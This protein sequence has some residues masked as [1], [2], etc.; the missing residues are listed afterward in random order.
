MTAMDGEQ[1]DTD[2]AAELRLMRQDL[3][4]VMLR[5]AGIVGWVWFAYVVFTAQAL[6]ASTLALLILGLGVYLAH[7]LATDRF[8]QACWVL[9]LSM[10][11]A[12]G[13][14]LSAHPFSLA[15]L[16][17][18]VI[19]VAAQALLPLGWALLAVGLAWASALVAHRDAVGASAEILSPIGLLLLYGLPFG[20]SAL[21]LRPL[22]TS[23]SWALAGWERAHES[24]VET[25]A[26]RA[27]LYRALRALEEAT[28]RI[29]RMNNEL[30]VARREAEEARAI[31]SRLTATVSHELRGPLNLILGFSKLMALSPESYGEPL[32]PAYRADIHAIYRNSR[33]LKALVD[34]ILDLSQIEAQQ[35]PLV[36]DLISLED[37]VVR[38]VAESIRPLAERKGL[39][40][41]LELAGD[42]PPVFGDPVRLRQALMNL[43]TNATRFTERGGIVVRTSREGG[44]VRVSVTDTGPGVR[45]ED[46][47][48]LFQ[49][50]H[51]IQP[52]RTREEGGSGLGLAISKHLIELHGGQIGVESQPGAGTTFFFTIPPVS[53]EGGQ[54]AGL[55]RT[56]ERLTGYVPPV[57]LAVHDDPDIVRLLGRYLEGYRVVGSPD[58]DRAIALAGQ[59]HARAILASSLLAGGVRA[60]LDR[61]GLDIPLITCGLPEPMM[62]PR[63][64]EVCGYLIKPITPELVASV[65]AQ[66]ERENEVNTVLLVD[67][68][69]DAVRLLERI[70]TAL[71]RPYTILKAYDGRQALE[72]MEATTPDVAFIDWVMPE[73]DG[74]E[75]VRL[76]RARPQTAQVPVVIISARDRLEGQATLAAPLEV[77]FKRPLSLA[78]GIKCLLGI[79]DVLQ[80]YGLNAQ[81]T[82]VSLSVRRV[83]TKARVEESYPAHERT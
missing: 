47:P 11:I 54:D 25:R 12:H 5:V 34:D 7:R 64:A 10:I 42:L 29:E 48:Q 6:V 30:I 75:L 70:L 74:L 13:V 50:F 18:V 59:L 79:L 66:V 14:V 61:E 45:A 83:E 22:R 27:E 28:Y 71:P 26:R 8:S 4:Q 23:V 76:M 44:W 15:I 80:G 32:P 17:A 43:L 37:D 55:M 21:T 52:T 16:F 58:P 56:R 67:D 38:R 2:L 78:K 72:L 19:A 81:D 1:A 31:K 40:L 24:L 53:A 82:P 39:Y 68:D 46:L 51:Q 65:L 60:A 73:M 63:F 57:C 36:K 9:I 20:M 49:E 3:L 33:H 62:V 41:R 35:L 77:R 69:P